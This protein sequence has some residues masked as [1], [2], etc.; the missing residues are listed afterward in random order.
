MSTEPRSIQVSRKLRPLRLAYLVD[1]GEEAMVRRAI[2]ASTCRWGGATCAI[3]PRYRR[4]PRDFPDQRLSAREIVAGY[5]ESFEPDYVIECYEGAASGLEIDPRQLAPLAHLETSD[6]GGTLS[7]GLSAL[8]IYRDAHSRIFRFLQRDPVPVV[9]PTCEAKGER[10]F[11]DALFGSLPN[12]GDIA[13]MSRAYEEAFEPHPT[14]VGAGSFLSLALGNKA[15]LTPLRLAQQRVS[16]ERPAVD[17]QDPIFLLVRPSR[18]HDVLDF[19]NL[20]ALGARVVPVP[21]THIAEFVV[22]FAELQASGEL[23]GD[24]RI[25][26]RRSATVVTP[27]SVEEEVGRDFQQQ[28]KEAGFQLYR[29]TWFPPLWDP[30]GLRRNNRWRASS[31]AESDRLELSAPSGRISFTPLSPDW[32]ED[33]IGFRPGWANVIRLREWSWTSDLGAVLPPEVKQMERLLS[34]VGHSPPTACSEGIVVRVE[35]PDLAQQWTLPS[36]TEVFSSWLRDRG[37][38]VSVSPA[39]RTAEQIVSALGGPIMAALV[40]EPPLIRL[41]DRAA[42]GL[43]EETSANRETH[44]R[45]RVIGYA[46]I[47]RV[48]REITDNDEARAK[49]RLARL[50]NA[51]VLRQGLR[52]SCSHC[53]QENWYPLEELGAAL[54][55]ERCLEEFNFPRSQPPSRERW[56]YRP[57][58]P[59]SAE[60]Y[61]HGGYAVALALRFFHTASVAEDE[62]SWTTSMR[63]KNHEG[64]ELEFDFGLWLRGFRDYADPPKL[65]LGEAKTFG[66]FEAND[67]KRIQH[68]AEAFPEALIVLATLRDDFEE[69]EQEAI[70]KLLASRRGLMPGRLIILTANELCDPNSSIGP[71]YVWRDKGKRFKTVAERFERGR[72]ELEDLSLATLELYARSSSDTAN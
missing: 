61:A 57:Q 22:A 31:E 14:V 38:E 9:T 49:G 50:L 15:P 45:R 67:L 36:G 52:V 13:F 20:R 23:R 46:E 28:M 25:G 12:S 40:A 48:L 26:D 64:T 4:R 6:M 69:E 7:Y 44:P 68:L 55:C 35:F 65:V 29:Q 58:G 72:F 66:A 5:L 47:N 30:E 42:R 39:G 17:H 56:A 1:P 41:I 70:R 62:A 53:E 27:F 37:Y 10:L 59:F 19:W 34:T 3:V 60:N 32:A 18:P 71:P 33:G 24:Y 2:E 54:H 16:R 8:S 11:C 63:L 21:A 51:G 43:V